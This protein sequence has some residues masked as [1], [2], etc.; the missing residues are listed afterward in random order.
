[1]AGERL[2]ES[3]SVERGVK[4]GSILSP[5]L[6]LLVMDPLLT[7]IQKTGL[8]LSINNFYAGGFL[9]ADDIRTLVSSCGSLESQVSLVSNFARETF[10][11][12]NIQKCEIVQFNRSSRVNNAP[13]C[14]VE[15][16]FLL[17]RDAAKCVGYWWKRDLTISGREHQE[18]AKI[19]LPL[20][21]SWILSR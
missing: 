14:V 18:S 1:M 7:Q 12:L 5:T 9:H 15:G 10:L 16:S 21:C 19:F 13:Q 8:G 20:W 4:Q 2:L 11:K 6:F 17:V 3:Y